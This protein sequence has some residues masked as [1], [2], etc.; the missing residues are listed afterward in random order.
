MAS[1]G[2]EPTTLSV[3][4]EA[5][6][7]VAPDQASVSA[8]VSSTA[9]SAAAAVAA[10]GVELS[11]VQAELTAIGG[12]ALTEHAM[13]RPLTWS[14]YSMHTHEEYDNRKR[15]PTGRY[16]ATAAL[17][18]TVRD[19][20]L[21]AGSGTSSPRATASTCTRSGGRST[22]TIRPGPRCA[23]TWGCSVVAPLD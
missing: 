16:R 7:V 22:T 18:V 4:G 17:L 3:R 19:F 15:G 23:P 2:G 5:R 6:R 20:A 9:G 12:Q 21:L 8:A 14:S 13:H 11:A 10:A 1:D